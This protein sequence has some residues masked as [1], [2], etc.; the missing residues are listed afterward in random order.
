MSLEQK[1][2]ILQAA[3]SGAC[4]VRDLVHK[5]R[6]KTSTIVSLTRKMSEEKLIEF[7]AVRHAIRGRP[8]KSIVCTALGLDFLE[9]YK[10]LNMKPLRARKADLERAAKDALYTRRLVE[11][12]HSPFLLF[13]ELNSIVRNIRDSSETH[14]AV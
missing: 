1:S 7:Q 12:G 3:A 10:K 14:Q 9:T 6:W 5:L 4:G 11:N 13:M 8:K 2:Q